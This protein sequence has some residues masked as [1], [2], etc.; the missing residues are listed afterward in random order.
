MLLLSMMPAASAFAASAPAVISVSL[1]SEQGTVAVGNTVSFTATATQ[2][3]NGTP[4]YQ[5]WYEGPNGNWHGTNWSTNNTFSLPPLQQGSYEV[6][7]YAMDKGQSV[8]VNSEGTNTNQF[9]N[10]DSS[11]TLTAPSLTNV[12]PGTTLTFT[13]SSK[14]LTDPV[15]QLWI[16]LPD[17]SWIASGDY[18]SSPTFTYTAPVA[19]DYHAVLYAKDLN[20]PQDAQFS[21]FSKATFDAFGQAAAVKLS[22]S[23][24]SLVA[25]G[26]A[27]DTITAT[28]VD[29]NGNT[30]ANF[31]GT[32]YL[33]VPSGEGSFS[34]AQTAKVTITNGTGS[35]SLTSASTPES[36]S[37]S[38]YDLTTSNSSPIATNVTYGSATVNEVTP[39][40]T[41]L[42]LTSSIPSLTVNSESDVLGD[43]ATVTIQQEDAAGT[44]Y[45][46]GQYV[47]VTLTGPGSFSSTSSVTTETLYVVGSTQVQVYGLK[48][49]AGT[50]T[51]TASA[52]GVQSGSVNIPAYVNTSPANITLTAKQGT[53][54]TGTPFTLYTVQLVDTNG[55][56]ITYGGN[57]NDTITVS[58]NTATVGGTLKYYEVS[59]GQPTSTS[60]PSSV[61]LVNGTYQFAVENT[62]VGTSSPTITVTDT[63][64][65]F[66]AS[67]PYFYQVGAPAQVAMTATNTQ[68]YVEAGHT[69]TYSAQLEDANGNQLMTAGQPVVFYF[70][71]TTGNSAGA[72]LPNGVSLT[73]PSNGY[74]AYTNSQGIASVTVNVPNTATSG[75]VFQV[76]ANL[77]GGTM[78]ASQG[79]TETVEPA[80]NFATSMAFTGTTAPTTMTV[81][82]LSDVLSG[83]TVT[84]YNAVQGSV[85][86]SDQLLVTTSNP[87]VVMLGG[88][89]PGTKSAEVTATNGV[90]TLP[91][92]MGMMAGT[93]T[94]T[95]TDLSNPSVPSISE[96]FTVQPGAPA[97]AALS[98][99]GGLVYLSTSAS[100]MYTLTPLTVAANTP[101]ALTLTNVD[102]T[103][104]PVPVTSAEANGNA[105]GATY[106]LTATNGGAFRLT[107]DGA[108]VT[109]VAIPVGQESV[110][111]YYVNPT[112]GTYTS[113][114]SAMITSGVPAYITA[115][116]PSSSTE[117][118]GT[119]VTITYT[120]T[121][122]NGNPVS[123]LSPTAT[124]KATAGT[125]DSETN[126]DSTSDA[127]TVSVAAGTNPGTYV[128][129]VTPGTYADG[130]TDFTSTVTF[131]V[132]SSLANSSVTLT[133]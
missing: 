117:T 94:V 14:N 132:N 69:V 104:N 61:Q 96:T 57:A 126:A 52:S 64:E 6:V 92:L 90:A 21:E 103:G 43:P 122:V 54:A 37:I 45:S 10:V 68:G 11:A 133:Y 8:P 28:V 80:S 56:P 5:F 60:L 98:L 26:Q 51:V 114:V 65:N 38:S 76:D 59:N 70:D 93:A 19:G 62:T 4:L 15:Y 107:P 87:N 130:D 108:D 2:S 110:T 89:A 63:T 22:A 85:T 109:S 67:A 115:G 25:D 78:S 48:G 35:V 119:P 12:A 72:T 120:V 55:N 41:Q 111:V 27:T 123:G 34:G 50:V 47:T 95:V 1:S 91:K 113:D 36:V 129:T 29:A 101:V 9:V 32:V 18:Q 7:V 30:V 31:N 49:E 82:T 124:I 102:A 127:G 88:Y 77:Q 16:Q 39:T 66:T 17:G 40:V 79:P 24:S 99:N 75:S 46:Q 86:T 100:S 74:V 131:T 84:L 106:A 20:A 3:G 42:A 71:G 125:A 53:T 128:V 116:T 105:A 13:A 83:Q 112:A 73:G 97:G 121:D 33:S 44:N 23:S 58:D 81:G 118:Y